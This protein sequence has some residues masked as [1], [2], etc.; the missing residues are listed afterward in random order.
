MAAAIAT[1]A[2]LTLVAPSGGS[3]IACQTVSAG[4]RL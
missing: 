2:P 3:T 1:G 4:I